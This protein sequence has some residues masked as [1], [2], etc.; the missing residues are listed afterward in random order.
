M[1]F[2]NVFG[3]PFRTISG[4]QGGA[5]L[6]IFAAPLITNI[7]PSIGTVTP[8]FARATSG[9]YFDGTDLQTAG[10]GVARFEPDG[11]L[12]EKLATK[13]LFPSDP[14]VAQLSTSS[15]VSDASEAWLSYF[16]NQ[17]AFGDNSVERTAYLAYASYSASTDYSFNIF[18]KMDDNSV[19]VPGT[20]IGNGDFGIIMYG[21]LATGGTVTLLADNIYKI[22]TTKNSASEVG[23]G[24][25][26][27]KYTGQS[28][29][30]FKIVGY[31]LELGKYCTSHVPTTISAV[32]R[33]QDKLDYDNTSR[34]AIPNEFTLIMSVTPKANGADYASGDVRLF[35]SEDSR[36]SNN[37]L[38]TFGD[39]SYD[40]F[41]AG[42]RGIF[43]I[44]VSD[45][46]KG[47]LRKYAFYAVQ[48]GANSR[49]GIFTNGS[50]V[51]NEVN[52]QTLD[53]SNQSL[54]IGYWDGFGGAFNVK[55]V[56]IYPG[57]LSDSK[58]VYLT[59]L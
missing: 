52:P 45:L 18:V 57:K 48:E 47:V 27:I 20:G 26:V 8:T 5:I 19:P 4:G 43:N 29:K 31:N 16:S 36:G 56:I 12:S 49:A 37:E 14:T 1:T 39:T 7:N 21:I 53:H 2:G 15:N 9:T 34:L 54:S 22:C 40:Y 10:S 30:S 28:S 46:S 13:R 58:L 51:L 3:R 25:G 17:I 32:T 59:S 38:R 33:N 24:F 41:P 6:P 11:Y 42:G 44:D 50:E 35:G 23:T 55:N